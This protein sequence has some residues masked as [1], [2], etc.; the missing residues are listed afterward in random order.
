MERFQNPNKSIILSL[1]IV[2]IITEIIDD[3]FDHLLGNSIIHSIIQLFIFIIFFFIVTKIFLNYHKKRINNLIPSELMNILIAINSEKEKGVLVNQ[4]K[5]MK[6]LNI[7]KPTM[8]K[9]L[10]QLIDFEYI[11]FEENGNSKYIK[12]TP[13]GM[14]VIK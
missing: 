8:K 10:S 13:L 6:I 7:T 3:V 9:R 4:A 1:F 11:S 12:I 2:F 14:S 5:L